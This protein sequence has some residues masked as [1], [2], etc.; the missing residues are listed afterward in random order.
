ML[1]CS[2]SQSNEAGL[3]SVSCLKRYLGMLPRINSRQHLFVSRRE[4]TCMLGSLANAKTACFGGFLQSQLLIKTVHHRLLTALVIV[5]SCLWIPMPSTAKKHVLLLHRNIS[6][7]GGTQSNERVLIQLHERSNHEERERNEGQR[8]LLSGLA[9]LAK[10][11]T[12]RCLHI[13]Q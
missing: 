9:S 11:T 5:H 13:T 2:S 3:A 7:Y 6:V 12:S 1:D 4:Y 10:Q 8:C